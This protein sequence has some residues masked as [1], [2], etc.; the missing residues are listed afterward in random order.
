MA[1]LF[2]ISASIGQTYQSG[3]SN[4]YE[5]TGT[6]WK[7]KNVINFN[8]FSASVVDRI[9]AAT[10]EGQ[11]ATTGSNTFIGGQVISGSILLSGS[12]IP[13]TES[14]S[15]TSSFSLG[16]PSN[17]WKDLYISQGSII[18]VDAVTQ[19]TSSFSIENN[20]GG[21]K[22][23]K[24]TAA[25]TA[26]AYLG[27]GRQ[28]TNLSA[29]TNWNNTYDS[30]LIRKTEQLTFSGDYILENGFLL[31]EGGVTSSIGEWIPTNLN[32]D[33]TITRTSDNTYRID[34]PNDGDNDGYLI[35][36]KYFDTE[37]TLSVDYAWSSQDEPGLDKPIYD[38]SEQE[39]VE[40]DTTNRLT[41]TNTQT[42]IGTWTI[43]VPANR[44]VAIGVYSTDS[45]CGSGSLS[46]TLPYLPNEDSVQYSAN[47][48]FK[49]EGTLFIGGNLL[50]KDSVIENNGKISVGGEVIL[51][52]NSSIDGTG[53][54]I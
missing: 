33:G 3:S 19:E 23:V 35:I 42:E 41:D 36:K 50:L 44:W 52:G 49:K 46:V 21:Q 38:V 31:I 47:K 20:A 18:F 22:T 25:I 39:P 34:G 32:G 4:T 13:T 29:N 15:F 53:I 12:I 26:S 40:V 8:E 7:I 10:N 17:A 11:F 45:C 30:Y 48:S 28:L 51:I 43:N 9:I 2:P 27:D 54:I 5:W 1:L 16:S 24:Y 14:G 6:Y 37:A